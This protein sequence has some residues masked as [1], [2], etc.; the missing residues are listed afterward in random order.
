[1]SPLFFL[2][3]FKKM[4]RLKLSM[5]AVATLALGFGSTFAARISIDDPE[6][7]CFETINGS[8]EAELGQVVTS[9]DDEGST[10]GCSAE[11]GDVC[12]YQVE[13]DLPANPGTYKVV[14]IYRRAD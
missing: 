2:F 9:V 6:E 12:C 8:S 5:L 7:G 13:E 10:F 14:H 3:K 4:K 11:S 1:M